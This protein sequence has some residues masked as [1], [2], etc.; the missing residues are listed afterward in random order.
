M[1]TKI[2]CGFEGGASVSKLVLLNENGDVLSTI[3]G[4][5]GNYLLVGREECHKR[6]VDMIEKAKV[7]A[8]LN[9]DSVLESLVLCMSGCE[10]DEK[11]KELENYFTTKNPHIMKSCTVTSD[12]IGP[13]YSA[14]PK[15]GLVLISGTGSNS[16]LLNPDGTVARCGGWGHLIGDEGSAMW[17][18]LKALKALFDD[19][20]N[21]V[22]CPHDLSK[23][24]ELILEYFKVND[25]IGIIERCYV[26]FDKTSFA[27]LC[28]KL[29]QAAKEEK[30]PL[31]CSLF[32]DA[33]KVLAQMVVALRPKVHKELLEMKGGLPIL[34][35][36][37]VFKSWPL[38]QQGFIDGI[39]NHYTKY[40]LMT[41]N[42]SSA[43]G[44]ASLGAKAIGIELPLDYEKNTSIL[45]SFDST[46]K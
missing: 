32:Y 16:L 27:G 22:K 29:A 3:E 41:L 2:F 8:G 44:A 35:V 28:T 43:I 13:L 23:V 1:S 4:P 19:E 7:T 21:L 11:N 37:S 39:G 40:T 46:K 25:K 36:G 31:C 15:G 20:D 24:K 33:G 10:V 6:I 38:L 42:C 45:Y 34:C 14:S 9:S 26:N 5:A 30:D 17:I 12:T 18:T